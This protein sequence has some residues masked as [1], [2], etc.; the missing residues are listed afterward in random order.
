[1]AR[2]QPYSLSMSTE[3]SPVNGLRPDPR[4]SVNPTEWCY[5]SG[6]RQA[7]ECKRKADKRRHR[8]SN[9]LSSLPESWSRTRASFRAD[10]T[11]SNCRPQR[12]TSPTKKFFMINNHRD[13]INPFEFLPGLRKPN[14]LRS[15][16]IGTII[17]REN[18][19]KLGQWTYLP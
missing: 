17:A 5:P 15:A 19:A 13:K 16:E 3:I 18:L 6:S 9:L 10:H 8:L 11:S 1:M 14:H 2:R 7:R 4:H 12:K